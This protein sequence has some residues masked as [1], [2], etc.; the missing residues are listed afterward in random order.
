VDPDSPTAPG[1]PVS[2]GAPAVPENTTSRVA[3]W[4]VE[5]FSL[6]SKKTD[7]EDGFAVMMSPLFGLPFNQE[8]N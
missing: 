2:P 4:L 5:T 1:R 3:G 6:L 8:I 7:V